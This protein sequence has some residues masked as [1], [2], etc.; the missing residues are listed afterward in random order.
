MQGRVGE[1]PA[2]D[3]LDEFL[4]DP[5]DSQFNELVSGYSVVTGF[6]YRSDKRRRD[7]VN[8]ECHQS[9]GTQ[10]RKAHDL[11]LLDHLRSDAVDPQR[12]QVVSRELA[13]DKSLHRLNKQR[14]DAVDCKSEQL[15]ARKISKT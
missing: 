14:R 15:I 8:S 2:L 4:R 11:E 6:L 10:I 9:I 7:A 5:G 1:S 13:V 12:N 3:Q